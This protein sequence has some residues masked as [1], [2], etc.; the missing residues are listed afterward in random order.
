[1]ST[2]KYSNYAR[3]TIKEAIIVFISVGLITT[4]INIAQ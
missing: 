3:W 2:N 1:M 4:W